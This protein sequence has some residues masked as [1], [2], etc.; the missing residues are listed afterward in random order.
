MDIITIGDALVTFN[1]SKKGPLRFVHTFE[2]KVGG[3][4]LN[5]AIGCARLGLKTGWM[6]RL[7]NDEFG[8]YIYN[9]VRGE[10]IDVSEVDF[11][12]GCPTSLYFKEMISSEKINSY[13]YRGNSPTRVY[14]KEDMNEQYIKQAKMLHISGVFPAVAESNK[15]LLLHLLK[16]AKKHQVTVSLDPNI[17]LKLWNAEEAAETFRSYLPY[18]DL[19]ITG[20][21]EAEILFD[22]SVPEEVYHAANGYD[23][24]HVVVKLGE[25]GAIGFR[26]GESV[27][28][29]TMDNLNVV[30]VIGA[31][32]GFAAGYLYSMIEKMDLKEALTYANTVAG[33]V[34]GVEGDNEGLP[35]KEEL[36]VF[37][38][39]KKTISR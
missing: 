26:N 36:E 16:I 14:R 30:D 12:D 28:V 11:V 35:Y 5:V 38:G 27:Y 31:G 3:A 34:I 17:R 19:L 20:E 1:P 32:D 33:H 10:G 23:I 22:T 37:L 7:G 2:K 4:E 21:E 8:R 25:K 24:H 13:Y 15:E 39:K 6:S 18:V 29:N 9:I